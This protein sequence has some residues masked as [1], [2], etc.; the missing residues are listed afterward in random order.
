MLCAAAAPRRLADSRSLAA[1]KK[2]M[3]SNE[4]NGWGDG[5]VD[6]DRFAMLVYVSGDQTF[7]RTTWRFGTRN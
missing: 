4:L 7:W 6:K 5:G 2:S 1:E 3:A